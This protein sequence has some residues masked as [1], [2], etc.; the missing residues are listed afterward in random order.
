[1]YMSIYYS[2][3]HEQT[4]SAIYAFLRGLKTRRR[5][6]YMK[7]FACCYPAIQIQQWVGFR[8]V[9]LHIVTNCLSFLWF[10]ASIWIWSKQSICGLGKLKGKIEGKNWPCHMSA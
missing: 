7:C 5:Y 9:L 8:R 2:L 6:Y 4:P 3:I 1:M 10:E